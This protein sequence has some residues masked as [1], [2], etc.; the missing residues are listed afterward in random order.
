MFS[1]A[2]AKSI[3]PFAGFFDQ[4]FCSLFPKVRQNDLL[5]VPILCTL[6]DGH[7]SRISKPTFSDPW[8]VIKTSTLNLP[9]GN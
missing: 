8:L 4:N 9:S 3:E 2:D 6:Q 7:A 1:V 5:A